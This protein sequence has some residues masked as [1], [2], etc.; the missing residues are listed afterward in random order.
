MNVFLQEVAA[1]IEADEHVVLIVDGAAW[2]KSD[3]LDVPDNITLIIL[4]PYSP[5]LNPIERAWR[6]IRSHWLS[7]RVFKDLGDILDAIED[8]WK[9]FI[10]NPSLA[11]SV[12]RSTWAENALD[13]AKQN[14]KL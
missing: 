3:G 14:L 6:Y 8:A 12:C 7:N 5:E 2:H 1:H 4:P 11:C 9:R 13:Q 10:A